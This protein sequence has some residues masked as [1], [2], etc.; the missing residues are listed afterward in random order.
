MQQDWLTSLLKFIRLNLGLLVVFLG[1]FV[2]VIWGG[3]RFMRTYQSS[4][5]SPEATPIA[6][7]EI[8]P[9]ATI[10]AVPEIVVTATPA[11]IKKIVATPAATL[12]PTIKPT[13]SPIPSVTPAATV[14]PTV[15]PNPSPSVAPLAI[16]TPKPTPSPTVAPLAIATPKAQ[17]KPSIIPT[18]MEQ[19]PAVTEQKAPTSTSGERQYTV[20]AGDSTWKVAEK[21]LG[22]GRHYPT[23]ERA[24]KLKHNQ[25]LAIGQVLTIPDQ[26]TITALPDRSK[27]TSGV[28][29]S[30]DSKES[31]AASSQPAEI[32]TSGT[33]YTVV[34]G[35]SLWK[36]A[37]KQMGNSYAWVSL[38]N[39]N[40][41]TIG[42]NPNR[43][44][45]GT[46]LQLPQQP[47]P[48]TK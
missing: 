14:R 7:A 24:S 3:F 40:K 46:V 12:L 45:P 30:M 27:I 17:V 36:I 28:S 10:S 23:I 16:A 25:H 32:K 13:A 43:I 29:I 47:S 31:T 39:A 1:F 21:L 4:L 35:D 48:S 18:P 44:Y 34:A 5:S 33:T 42:S 8:A 6:V 41:K 9:I 2:V 11:A 38:Y 22:D 15:K 19:R 20:V 26:K 37:Q